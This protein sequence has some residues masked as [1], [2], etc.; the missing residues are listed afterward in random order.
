M[1]AKSSPNIFSLLGQDSRASLSFQK[2]PR[3]PWEDLDLE[4][5]LPT[6]MN[7]H[8]HD[9]D[10][11]WSVESCGLHA[12]D[13]GYY[14]YDAF[15]R[16]G[17][18]RDRG[19]A[20]WGDVSCSDDG[21]VL[22]QRGGATLGYDADV[23]EDSDVSGEESTPALPPNIEDEVPGFVASAGGG[24]GEAGAE[25]A[26][27]LGQGED[28]QAGE[29]LQIDAALPVNAGTISGDGEGEG[30]KEGEEVGEGGIGQV[31][32]SLQEAAEGQASATPQG[33]A[34][35]GEVEGIQD[36]GEGEKWAEQAGE[37][38]Q[39]VQEGQASASPHIGTEFAAD[40]LPIL[41]ISAPS[42]ASSSSS[43]IIDD[44]DD[45]D[46]RNGNIPHAAAAGALSEGNLKAHQNAQPL[47]P[48]AGACVDA[49]EDVRSEDFPF[50][51]YE[52]V[53]RQNNRI[54]LNLS[55]S[56]NFE[57]YMHAN[58]HRHVEEGDPRAFPIM[59]FGNNQFDV[60]CGW[61]FPTTFHQEFPLAHV[62]AGMRMT[63][64][65]IPLITRL[66]RDYNGADVEYA[67][68][69]PPHRRFDGRFINEQS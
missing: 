2:S 30:E 49:D 59:E 57:Q 38:P 14:G 8:G 41:R 63:L 25:Q 47:Q 35:E 37:P 24:E 23:S 7:G 9:E 42:Y 29:S 53:E 60:G 6:T 65:H 44:S 31:G 12:H 66:Y 20:G 52:D 51:E 27:S 10:P 43:Y 36:E 69:P 5:G 48:N 58:P 22:R 1:Q 18:L 21:Y 32:E 54:H 11:M 62:N 45:S 16:S 68:F 4:H 26:E 64:P 67:W 19:S 33:G 50:D 3:P 34:G 39:Q 28:I 46:G 13:Y 56:G 61:T 17:E 40:G 15:G 55:I